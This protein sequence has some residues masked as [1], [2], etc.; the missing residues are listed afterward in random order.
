[1]PN[2][3]RQRLLARVRRHPQNVSFREFEDLVRGFGFQLARIVG[4]HHFYSRDDVTEVLNLQPSKGEAKAY[5]IR[6]CLKLVDEYN[7]KLED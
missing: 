6:Q 4:S 5:Q 3:A 2:R 7:L 1:V